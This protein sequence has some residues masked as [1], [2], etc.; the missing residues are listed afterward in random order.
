MADKLLGYVSA[1]TAGNEDTHYN[2]YLNGEYLEE[3]DSAYSHYHSAQV[4]G[5]NYPIKDGDTLTVVY[6][7]YR[8]NSPAGGTMYPYV[9]FLDIDYR[10]TIYLDR[11][12]DYRKT[13]TTTFHNCC[14]NGNTTLYFEDKRLSIDSESREGNFS[15]DIRNVSY[16]STPKPGDSISF[17]VT[18][19]NSA[20][21]GT[22]RYIVTREDFVNGYERGTT[23]IIDTTTSQPTSQRFTDTVSDVFAN[24]IYGTIRYTA[25]I[26]DCRFHTD[27]YKSVFYNIS[28]G[29]L[30]EASISA[31]NVVA[32]LTA[33]VEWEY[34]FDGTCYAKDL[35]CYYKASGSSSYTPI[36][37][38]ISSTDT[39]YYHSIPESYN[40]GSLY[41]VLTYYTSELG[42][43]DT[44]TAT[45]RTYTV[46]DNSPPT[47]PGIPTF[48]LDISVGDQIT[49]S[50]TRSTDPDGDYIDYILEYS[51]NNGSSWN[52]RAQIGSLTY[53]FTVPDCSFLMFRV[54]ARDSKGLESDYATSLVATISPYTIGVVGINGVLKSLTGSGYV[55]I[56][57]AI[58]TLTGNGWVNIDGVWKPINRF[59][60]SNNK[61]LFRSF[62]IIYFAG[63]IT[64]YLRVETD[65]ETLFVTIGYQ[66]SYE[67]EYQSAVA[68]DI[69]YNGITQTINESIFGEKRSVEFPYDDSVKSITLSSESWFEYN[70][71]TS[72]SITFTWRTSFNSTPPI[73][74]YTCP[75]GRENT[76]DNFQWTITDPLGRP[77]A[78]GQLLEH[79]YV[80]SRGYWITGT[81]ITSSKNTTGSI[82]N[83]ISSTYVKGSLL[84]YT[85]YAAVYETAD[86]AWEDYVELVEVISP[87][88]TISTQ[89]VSCPPYEIKYNNAIAGGS[90]NVTWKHIDDPSY[91]ATGF[92]LERSLNGGSFVNI[93]NGL[94]TSFVDTIS[95]D[96]NTVQYRIRTVGRMGTSV[97]TTGDI[98]KTI[99][100]IH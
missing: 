64:L 63:S 4:W 39:K 67:Q 38:S 6:Y 81:L 42:S 58:K 37:L 94:S 77:T 17:D 16:H 74:T 45:S 47:T 86:A 61:L 97:Y 57:G 10:D 65:G 51:L 29:S 73:V 70:A 78:A 28:L 90:L 68:M 34:D 72:S 60:N 49:V 8:Q 82:T 7:A 62:S 59:Q 50:W 30:P 44:F 24:A 2:I 12:E 84:Y 5:P 96:T 76:R 56:D 87:I 20:S 35:T 18:Y 31:Y 33:T 19:S 92:E 85:F 13:F 98:V 32:R 52:R 41:Y 89:Y 54:K 53:L 27:H 14:G 80:Q 23:T 26:Y 75:G 88:Y 15:V 83:Y 40:G 9:S 95:A 46:S 55:N 43:S 79:L 48:P 69:T 99:R 100:V 25:T 93:Y 11:G 91:P 36:T 71:V 22:T 21:G 1:Y 66:S 3:Y